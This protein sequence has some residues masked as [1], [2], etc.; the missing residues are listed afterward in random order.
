MKVTLPAGA[1]LSVVSA[2]NGHEHSLTV[3][4]GTTRVFDTGRLAYGD[5]SAPAVL[6]PGSYSL[7]DGRYPWIRG[8]ITVGEVPSE[9]TL[10]VGAVFLPEDRLDAYRNLFRMNG[11]RIESEHM[12]TYAGTQQ[13]LVI[14]STD[15]D[16]SQAGPKL[17]LLVTLDTLNCWPI[18]RRGIVPAGSS[19]PGKRP[20]WADWLFDAHGGEGDASC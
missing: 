20:S 3:R 4:S 18:E 8:E 10:L 13:V 14:F 7:I 1:T 17:R 19:G 15:E 12:F 9:G 6:A 2:D 11:F 5:L 16:L